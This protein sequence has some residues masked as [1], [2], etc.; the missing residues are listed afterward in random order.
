MSLIMGAY[1]QIGISPYP[2]VDGVP[3]VWA[4]WCFALEV[5]H[6]GVNGVGTVLTVPF[7]DDGR[8]R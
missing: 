8:A 3:E 4:Y 7:S 1:G 6:L 2:L 5:N